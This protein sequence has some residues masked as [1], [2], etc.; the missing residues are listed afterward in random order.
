MFNNHIERWNDNSIKISK[1]VKKKNLY[2]MEKYKGN[3][4]KFLIKI[5]LPNKIS[6]RLEGKKILLKHSLENNKNLKN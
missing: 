5:I 1:N 4:K 6:D 2:F 3:Y